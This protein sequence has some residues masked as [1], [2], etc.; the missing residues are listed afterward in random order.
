MKVA[1][2]DLDRVEE[3]YCNMDGS[4]LRWINEV[5]LTLAIMSHPNKPKTGKWINER[6]LGTTL[7]GVTCSNCMV[8]GSRFSDYCPNCGADMRG[9]N[10]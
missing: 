1:V 3:L 5:D 8:I 9:T 7:I 6:W 2:I 4:N 10:K